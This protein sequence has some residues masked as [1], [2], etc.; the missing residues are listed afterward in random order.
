MKFSHHFQHD[1]SIRA[2]KVFSTKTKPK[3][4]LTMYK[5]TIID[6]KSLNYPTVI[7]LRSDAVS[8]PT[9]RMRDAM[10][11]A[12]VG[13][14]VF[15]EVSVTFSVSKKVLFLVDILFV[16]LRTQPFKS[17]KINVLNYSEKRQVS[18]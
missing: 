16:F 5:P 14:D 6:L 13:D 8:H 9:Q 17:L 15:R 10:A 18:L 12:V 7:D 2:K 11:N 4:E 1:R 3:K